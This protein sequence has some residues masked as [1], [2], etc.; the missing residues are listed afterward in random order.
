MAKKSPPARKVGRYVGLGLIIL[1][2]IVEA[3]QP[4]TVGPA[5]VR[6]LQALQPL[7]MAG[8]VLCLTII[9]IRRIFGVK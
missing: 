9:G 4:G 8:L 2:V 5:I 3:V 7:I 6:F 1:G